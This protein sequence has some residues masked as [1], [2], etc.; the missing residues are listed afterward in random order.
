MEMVL[1]SLLNKHLM[2]KIYALALLMTIS[3]WLSAQTFIYEDFSGGTMPPS[4]WS[5]DAHS[6]NWSVE[7]S[8]TASGT[9]PEAVLNYSP[10]FNGATRLISPAI[11]LTGHT[12]VVLSFKHFLDDYAGAGYSIGV[13]TR[14][15]GGAWNIAWTSSPTGDVG[16]EEL[17]LE[18]ANSDVG[19]SDFQFCIFFNGNSYNIDYWYIDD[20]QLFAPYALD[21]A[22]TKITTPIY[23]QGAVPVEGVLRNLGNTPITSVDVSWKVSED[24]TYTTSFTGLSLD[25]GETFAYTCDDLFHFPIG[26]YTLD[27]WISA[28]NGVADDD[29]GNDLKSKVM[30]VYSHSIDRKPSFEE[31]TSS[32]CAPCATFNTSFNPWAESHADQIT[33][34][35]YQMNWP[36]PGDPY[37]TE[38]GGVR[39]NYYGVSYVPWP[40][41]NGAYVD[42]SIGAVQAAFDNAIL[43]P[44]L[45][46]IESSHTLDG[47]MITVNANI[48]PF[49]NFQD[50][51]AH[52][53]V[54]EN[55]TTGNTGNNGET[56]FHHVMMKMMPDANGT[57]L[58]LNDREAVQL[59]ESFDLA[60]TNVEEFTDLSVVVLFQDNAT[61]EIF[62]SAYSV[63]DGAF[64]VEA[65]GSSI[66][67]NGIPVPDFNPAILEYDIEL[68]EGTTEVPVVEGI[69]LDP[70]ATVV[71]VPAWE[72]P[73]T[74]VVDVF[75]E[76]LLHRN[77]YQVHFTVAVG[78][79]EPGVSSGIRVYPNPA[80]DR[81]NFA[82]F[83]K[84]DISITGITGQTVMSVN[85]FKG[86]SLDIS[87]LE[88]GIYTV[89]FVL[90]D[91]TVV[92]RK[93]TVLK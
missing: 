11:D 16:P 14:S 20:I 42:Y 9:A 72:L 26:G 70:N 46:K 64:S 7:A 29:P 49:A 85:G 65:Q 39:R 19:A 35:K 4:G 71:V 44:G 69:S 36:S 75:S 32:T 31:F 53:I 93:I 40:Q 17:I 92:N 10:T 77:T 30:S 79:D 63:Q 12:S 45:A 2:K 43:Q 81:I 34:I 82:G 37:Y 80:K 50:F 15:A 91:K 58:N 25:F 66:T 68:P 76:D 23:V 57:T 18:I 8:A 41:C 28:V 83:T 54:I 62:Q 24:A 86:N 1:Y 52:I 51:R 21:G 89:R 33:L 22:M 74:A 90:E 60:G 61:K 73:G 59:T 47:T 27:V 84:A 56:A 38:E 5:I 88:N 13:G 6:A 48:L 55:T 67:Y 87:A 3:C 78:V